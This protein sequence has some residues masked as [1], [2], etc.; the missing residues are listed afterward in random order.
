MTNLRNAVGAVVL[1]ALGGAAPAADEVAI[2][3]TGT[4]SQFNTTEPIELA[5]LYKKQA[6][7]EKTLPLEVR[8]DDG[9]TVALSVPF[10]AAGKPESRIVTVYA[11]V[12]KPGQYTATV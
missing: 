9:S 12:L 6:T 11:G 8:H 1:L 3:L 5:V 7:N 2:D 4:R 10:A